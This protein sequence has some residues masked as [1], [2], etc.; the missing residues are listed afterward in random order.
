MDAFVKTIVESAA[1]VV[2]VRLSE[3]PPFTM[4]EAVGSVEIRQYGVRLAAETTVK[5]LGDDAARSEAFSRLAGYIF[6]KNRTRARMA[7]TAPVETS[8]G[9]TAQTIA[10]TAPVETAR[11]K[12]GALRMRFFLPSSVSA[13]TA[14]IPDDARVTIGSVP[15]QTLAVLRFS[16]HASRDDLSARKRELL[17]SLAPTPWKAAGEPFA[18]FYDP[19]FTPP[20]LRR[21]EVAV[22]VTK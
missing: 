13:E 19:P 10:M 14:P 1:S 16:G 4:V 3:Q 2:G 20:F 12:D 18:L 5:G 6:G 8:G 11:A 7:M 9:Q 17:D 21:N 22:A 15:G